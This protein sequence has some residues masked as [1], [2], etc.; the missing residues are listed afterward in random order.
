MLYDGDELIPLVF[1]CGT[2]IA[3]KVESRRGT[4]RAKTLDRY[5]Y[6]LDKNN[7]PWLMEGQQPRGNRPRE[8]Q[9]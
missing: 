6:T 7:T 8:D 1:L 3:Q 9:M 2:L 5:L 4:K